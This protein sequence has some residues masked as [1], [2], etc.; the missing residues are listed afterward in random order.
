[1]P[2]YAGVSGANRQV[3]KVPVGVSGA[4]RECKSA[5]AGAGGANR[6]VF[7]SSNMSSISNA[8]GLGGR[9]NGKI[10]CSGNVITVI[11]DLEHG[12]TSNHPSIGIK[13]VYDK[14]LSAGDHTVQITISNFTYEGSKTSAWVWTSINPGDR[15]Y[16]QS[17]HP[18]CK[19]I[20]DAGG[21]FTY[22]FTLPVEIPTNEFILR[23]PHSVSNTESHIRF[24]VLAG[25]I[26]I[27]GQPILYPNFSYDVTYDS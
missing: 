15:S 21:M 17:Y 27:D 6:Q 20:A 13:G 2:I 14:T 5:W 9:G 12:S 7:A 26:K 11:S 25:N 3:M 16:A 8:S 10:S 18:T 22:T 19:A 24:D 1:M 23:F 4:N